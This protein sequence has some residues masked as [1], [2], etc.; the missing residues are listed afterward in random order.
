MSGPGCKDED[1][2]YPEPE[3][4]DEPE[5]LFVYTPEHFRAAF[6]ALR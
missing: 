1:P 3:D 5:P 4:D 2:N 6:Q